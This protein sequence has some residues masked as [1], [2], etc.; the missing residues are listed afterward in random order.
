MI[1]FAAVGEGVVDAEGAG[2]EDPEGVGGV[3]LAGEE[4]AGVDANL[5]GIAEA[6]EF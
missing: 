6:V 1:C 5:A 4:V 3:A 2:E